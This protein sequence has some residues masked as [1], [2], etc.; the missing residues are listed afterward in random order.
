MNN[1]PDHDKGFR[2]R[3][4]ELADHFD[5]VDTADVPWVEATD[6]EIV[7]D[8]AEMVPLRLPRADLIQ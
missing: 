5:A 8:E 2:Q 4:D 3:L 7:R 1:S 6:A